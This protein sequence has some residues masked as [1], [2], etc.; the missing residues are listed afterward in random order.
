MP[1]PGRKIDPEL[2]PG[3]PT[4]PSHVANNISLTLLPRNMLYGV[5]GKLTGPQ[6]KTIMML[7]SEDQHF[8]TRPFDHVHPLPWIKIRRIE[9]RWIF[10]AFSPFPVGKG[11]DAKVSKSDELVLLPGKLL[12]SRDNPGCFTDD[13]I[14]GILLPYER[15]ILNGLTGRSILPA[16]HPFGHGLITGQRME[17]NGEKQ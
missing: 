16:L 2:D 17:D 1:V 5:I 6:T 9:Q 4:S 14:G 10:I 15:A 7:G 3:L 13:L 12:T 8:H 11:I